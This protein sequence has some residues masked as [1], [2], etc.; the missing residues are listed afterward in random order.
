[1]TSD[2]PYDGTAIG[3][4]F[5]ATQP[6][7]VR[8][9]ASSDAATRS[10]AFGTIVMIYWKPIYKYIRLRSTLS[11]EDCEDLTQEFFRLAFEKD[12]L[13]RFDARRARFRT[14][15]RTC[16]DGHVSNWRRA[17]LRTK[18]GGQQEFVAMD[19][20]AAERE[21]IDSAPAPDADVEAFFHAEWVRSV[22]EL[23]LSRLRGECERSEKMTHFALFVRYDVEGAQR[24]AQPS[25]SELATEFGLPATQVTNF[26]AWT[27][28]VFRQQVLMALAELTSDD[29]EYAEA[30]RDLLGVSTT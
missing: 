15:V 18:R 30:V 5:P 24:D 29:V 16:V 13:S 9:L 17:A 27:R 19:F 23:S 11:H 20:G 7:V 12:W 26:L 4:G 1:M 14:F 22:F 28:R 21:F 3:P 10:R 25:Y 6:S 2:H 8:A